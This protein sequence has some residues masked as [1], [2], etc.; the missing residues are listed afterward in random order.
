MRHE[1][2][3]LLFFHA[4]LWSYSEVML[5][6]AAAD[7]VCAQLGYDFGIVSNSACENFGGSNLC[8]AVGSPVAMASLTCSGT[9]LD[10]QQCSYSIPD[11]DCAEHVRDSVVFCGEHGGVGFVEPGALRLLD[12][13]GAPSFDGVGRLEIFHDDAW[14][15]ICH[16]GFNAGA[17]AVA[18]KA[19]GF[20]GASA[21]GVGRCQGGEG[22]SLCG[23][24]APQVS[25]FACAGQETNLLACPHVDGD[26]VFCAQEESVV[27]HCSG[28]GDAQGRPKRILG[29]AGSAA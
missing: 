7:V 28:A 26:A 24:V 27:L 6:Q 15:P 21:D 14:G 8:G 11:S 4:L 19:M 16:S 9:E 5:F 29:P 23:M 18:C 12:A 22:G 17:A 10:I 1:S 25:E 20:A 3:M 13:D 2:G